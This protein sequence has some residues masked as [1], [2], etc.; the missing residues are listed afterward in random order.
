MNGRNRP[1]TIAVSRR[2]APGREADFA[3]WARRIAGEAE[4]FPGHLGS[5]YIR[6]AEPG[7]EHT[8][9]YRFDSQAHFD[10]WQDSPERAR[11]VEDSRSFIGGE[12]RVDI[13]TGLEYW[14]HDPAGPSGN[15]PVWKQAALTWLGLYPVVLAIGYT[16]GV[17]I[18]PWPLPAR[19]VLTSGASVLMMTWIVMPMVTR[20][21]RDWLRP[22]QALGDPAD[23]P[24]SRIGPRA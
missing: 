19:A 20:A 11:L 23:R 22:R 17:L 24:D 15:P 8:L 14:F 5:G 12:P 9:I 10:G 6:P 21:F 4:R 7:G 13:T 16:L 18:A 3:E 1:V 2:V